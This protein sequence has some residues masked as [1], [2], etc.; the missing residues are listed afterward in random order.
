MNRVS[1][2]VLKE[3]LDIYMYVYKVFGFLK[4]K[5]KIYFV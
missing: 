5:N 3:V 2:D 1:K 4:I